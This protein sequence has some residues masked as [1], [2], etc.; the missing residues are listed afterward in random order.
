MPC[1]DKRT[2]GICFSGILIQ[3]QEIFGNPGISGKASTIPAES[4]SPEYAGRV[5]FR[6]FKDIKWLL[7]TFEYLS[8]LSKNCRKYENSVY[9]IMPHSSKPGMA[10]RLN[11]AD[12]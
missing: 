10:Y 12:N 11:L 3:N 6:H 4:V 5:G 1:V 9:S 8:E 7:N 2:V